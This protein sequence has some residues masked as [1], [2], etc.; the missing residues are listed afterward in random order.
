[1]RAA[2]AQNSGSLKGFDTMNVALREYQVD[3][4]TEK[5][6]NLAV[7]GN[8]LKVLAAV[9][10]SAVFMT[11]VAVAS[12]WLKL[13]IDQRYQRIDTYNVRNAEIG[14]ENQKLEAELMRLQSYD[15]IQ[16]DLTAAGV[17]MGMPTQVFYF[18]SSRSVGV[19]AIGAGE[20]SNGSI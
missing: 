17:T 20:K 12:I 1:M 11:V 14:R 8:W 19:S 3:F 13:E 5:S 9:V 6:Q 2:A 10:F 16:Q 7:A 18:D 15:R 4:K